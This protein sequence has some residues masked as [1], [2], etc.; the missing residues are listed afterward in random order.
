MSAQNV[1]TPG[2]TSESVRGGKMTTTWRWLTVVIALAIFLQAVLASFGLFE[3]E[4]QLVDIH[5][6]LGNALPLVALAQAI[7]ATILFRRGGLGK[8]ELWIGIA[9][10]PVVMGQLSLGYETGSSSTAI[11][12]H[13]PLGVLLMSLATVNALLAWIPRVRA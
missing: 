6:E 5:R 3:G 4:A 8:A 7:L 9:L 10:V 13:I 2:D 11:A 1:S 12:L